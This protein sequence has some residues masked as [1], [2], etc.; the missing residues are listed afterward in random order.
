[1]Q[2]GLE[3][4]ERGDAVT[5]SAAPGPT[6]HHPHGGDD[7]RRPSR[8][9]ARIGWRIGICSADA[10]RIGAEVLAVDDDLAGA[11]GQ[12]DASDRVLAHAGG[13]GT[14]ER[15]DLALVNWG[16]D[17]LTA[18]SGTDGSAQLPSKD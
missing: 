6:D 14:A 2:L 18:A 13:I 4:G 17:R 16:G 10:Q 12:P 8:S 7:V 11:A 15:I 5:Q 1:M 3:I 9:A